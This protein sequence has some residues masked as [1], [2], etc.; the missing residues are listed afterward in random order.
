MMSSTSGLLAQDLYFHSKS[1]G[2][3]DIIFF[4]FVQWRDVSQEISWVITI[5]ILK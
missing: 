1:L 4:H 2:P 5:Y 3:Y